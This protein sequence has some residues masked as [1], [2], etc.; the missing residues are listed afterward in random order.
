VAPDQAL[1]NLHLLLWLILYLL[2][3]G[4]QL[5]VIYP[6]SRFPPL[7]SSIFCSV[8]F[9]ISKGDCIGRCSYLF[10]TD[11][12]CLTL[13]DVE[14]SWSVIK[15]TILDAIDLFIPKFKTITHDNQPVWFNSNIRHQI[16][17]LGFH[18]FFHNGLL[19]G[20]TL[21][22]AGLFWIRFHFFL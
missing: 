8:G 6:L 15:S 13:L 12:S 3:P 7:L 11:F 2:S 22:T 5:F 21:F 9:C 1:V 16:K 4:C 14:M 18:I 20:C 10:D 19:G 17:C